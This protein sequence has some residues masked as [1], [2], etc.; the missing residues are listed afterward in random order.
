MGDDRP[1][2]ELTGPKEPS[3]LMPGLI[4][5][6]A[7][8]TIEGETLEDDVAGKV[9]LRRPVGCAQKVHSSSHPSRSQGLSMPAGMSAHLADEINAISPGQLVNSSYHIVG[10]GI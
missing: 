6:P 7:G 5:L 8:H 2:F 3:H 9:H 1:G 4:H 10:S